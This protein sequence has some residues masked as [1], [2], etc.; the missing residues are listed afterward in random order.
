MKLR[1]PHCYSFDFHRPH[2]ARKV[3]AT[4]GIIAGSSSGLIGAATGA[5]IGAP[6]GM[7]I[8]LVLGPPGAAVGGVAGAILGA[9]I[10]GF[11]GCLAGA[12]LGDSIDENILLPY[13]CQSCRRRFS[14]PDALEDEY[15]DDDSYTVTQ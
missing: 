14:V 8:G 2:H 6:L 3:G 10:G 12:R 4:I 9:L 13:V 7:E 11:T 15:L 1:C 5:E